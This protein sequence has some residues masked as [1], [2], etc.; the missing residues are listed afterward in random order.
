MRENRSGLFFCDAKY[1]NTAYIVLCM[2]VA[3]IQASNEGVMLG[4]LA[5]K[6]NIDLNGYPITFS[7]TK[8]G[9]LSVLAG[10][11][12]GGEADKRAFLKELAKSKRVKN[13][14]TR[15]DFVML[16]VI[17]PPTFTDFYNPLI[18][19]VRPALIS[20][21]GHTIYAVGAFQRKA[22]EDFAKLLKRIRNAK[23]LSIKHER[24]GNITI[25]KTAPDLTDKQK[26]AIELAVREGYYEYPRKTDLPRLAKIMKLSYSTY[27]AHL[28]K[29]EKALMPSSVETIS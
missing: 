16:Q 26:Q 14:E 1:I 27:Q 13:I 3:K 19:H 8:E 15:K 10:T 9:I 2:W 12:S 29:A 21:K 6:H 5:E 22:V 18:I 11:M 17:E 7:K 4:I 25:T 24:V 20:K 23:L 28:R